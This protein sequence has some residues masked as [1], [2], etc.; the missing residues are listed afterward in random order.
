MKK[1]ISLALTLAIIITLASCG[2]KESSQAVVQNAIE[3]VKNMD[4]ESMQSYWGQDKFTDAFSKESNTEID[5]DSLSMLKLLVTNLDYQIIETNEKKDTATVTVQI[6]NLDMAQVMSEFVAA[7]FEN[8]LSYAYLPDEQKPTNEEVEMKY[9]EMMCDLLG[10]E[11]NPTVT[12]TVE[13]EL[14]LVDNK[15]V[16]NFNEDAIDAM[17]GGLNSF[18]KSMN[19]A[20]SESSN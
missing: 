12:N 16:I 9:T 8:T 13:I 15:W 10:R 2:P 1:G 7:A 18:S 11:G 17:L 6:T 3:S 14:S 4:I 19:D 20:F 5:S